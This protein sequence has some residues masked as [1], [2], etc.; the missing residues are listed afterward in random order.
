MLYASFNIGISYWRFNAYNSIVTE[1]FSDSVFVTRKGILTQYGN[2]FFE[3]KLNYHLG[4]NFELHFSMA[5]V[6]N[7]YKND[8]GIK[9][10]LNQSGSGP[11]NN[12]FYFTPSLGINYFF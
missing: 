3:P 8:N 9:Y 7:I 4:E 12:M 10:F 11:F 5:A 2:I 1:Q 6:A